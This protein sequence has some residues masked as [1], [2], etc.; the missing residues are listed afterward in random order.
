[1]NRIQ[2]INYV[3]D[4]LNYRHE[5]DFG[6][7]HKYY[8]QAEYDW[9]INYDGGPNIFAV[10]EDKPEKIERIISHI[11][12]LG[13]YVYRLVEGE[14]ENIQISVDRNKKLNDLGIC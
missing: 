4:R 13:L 6:P 8:Y 3:L 12:T 10:S 1:M 5:D 2:Q 9:I 7:Y 11:P 14:I